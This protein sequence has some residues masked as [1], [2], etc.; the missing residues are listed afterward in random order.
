MMTIEQR[1][2]QLER[3]RTTEL[4]TTHFLF[5]RSKR[6]VRRKLA[7]DR[8]IRKHI[9]VALGVAAVSGMLLAPAPHPRPAEAEPPRRSRRRGSAFNLLAALA[10][11]FV[12]ALRPYVGGAAALGRAVQS[13]DEPAPSKPANHSHLTAELLLALAPI[14]GTKLDWQNLVERAMQEL[15]AILHHKA[16]QNDAPAA[17]AHNGTHQPFQNRIDDPE[18]GD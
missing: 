11:T 7:P 3:Q 1:I 12:P 8:I 9:G 5:V 2:A 6:D 17:A 15:Q 14:I 13:A 10:A 18:D 4:R 16:R